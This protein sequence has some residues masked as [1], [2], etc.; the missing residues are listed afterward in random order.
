MPST[1]PTSPVIDPQAI[2]PQ[3]RNGTIARVRRTT[4]SHRNR[5][6]FLVT[7]LRSPHMDLYANRPQLQFMYYFTVHM[8]LFYGVYREQRSQQAAR[9]LAESD[10]TSCVPPEPWTGGLLFAWYDEILPFCLYT[11]LAICRFRDWRTVSKWEYMAMAASWAKSVVVLRA[12]YV[13]FRAGS[14]AGV[15]FPDN[16]VDY[17]VFGLVRFLV[18]GGL[19]KMVQAGLTREWERSWMVERRP[20]RVARLHRH[21]HIGLQRRAVDGMGSRG[22]QRDPLDTVQG[23]REYWEAIAARNW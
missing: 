6:S 17:A 23:R 1:T 16:P 15:G 9:L 21:V 22:R 18:F 7:I 3:R 20:R 19:Y 5:Q 2:S 8:L 14:T 10:G 13:A 12:S 11:A 4:R